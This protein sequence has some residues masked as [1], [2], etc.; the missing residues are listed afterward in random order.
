MKWLV[1]IGAIFMLAG[2]GGGLDFFPD[3]AGGGSAAAP[4]AFVFTPANKLDVAVNTTVQSNSVTVTGT[5]PSGWVIT[6]SGAPGSAYSINGAAYTST[7]GIILPNQN[8]VVQHTSS[9]QNSTAV[10]TTVIVG[11]YTT[12]FQSTTI[13]AI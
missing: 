8:L 2:C 9:G 12:S 11:T 13:A 10:T 7:S 3:N 1:L 5:N 6:I 4:N